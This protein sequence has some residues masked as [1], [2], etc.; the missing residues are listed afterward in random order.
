MKTIDV[1]QL[2]QWAL[3]EQAVEAVAAMQ[4]VSAR[5]HGQSSTATVC[6]ILA[7]GATVDRSAGHIKAMGAKCHPDAME[8]W[9]A[10]QDLGAECW[11]DASLLLAYGRTRSRPDWEVW[12]EI[13]PE[14]D[15]GGHVKVRQMA[16]PLSGRTVRYCAFEVRPSPDL[17]DQARATYDR[18][19]NAL[20]SLAASLRGRLGDHVVTG[21]SAPDQ[22]WRHPRESAA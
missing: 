13:M 12:P 16:D 3:N 15:G 19:R 21:P 9:L 18:W 1:E 10:I 17:C 6:E 5:G 4:R 2:V 7:L 11:T 8:C 22:P 20:V 14:I